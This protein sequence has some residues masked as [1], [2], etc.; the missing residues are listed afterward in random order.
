MQ[1]ENVF[2]RTF[3]RDLVTNGVHTCDSFLQGDIIYSS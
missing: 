2:L 1:F 3:I